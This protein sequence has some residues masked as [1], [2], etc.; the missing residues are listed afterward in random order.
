[1]KLNLLLNEL[2][3]LL[4]VLSC[5]RTN[6][7]KPRKAQQFSILLVTFHFVSKF[8]TM[9]TG[10]A[11]SG[12]TVPKRAVLFKWRQSNLDLLWTDSSEYSQTQTCLREWTA[13]RK[14]YLDWLDNLSLLIVGLLAHQIFHNLISNWGKYSLQFH[15]KISYLWR[16]WH[17]QNKIKNKQTKPNSKKSITHI[18]R[19]SVHKELSN[20]QW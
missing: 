2:D 4:S 6:C 17:Y 13:F 15:Y 10:V 14:S 18:K 5:T 1:M 8:K 7:L 9:S 19:G 12:L 3:V 16:H 20:T 11:T